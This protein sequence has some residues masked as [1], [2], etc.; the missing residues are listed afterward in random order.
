MTL[1]QKTGLLLSVVLP[2]LLFTGTALADYQIGSPNEETTVQIT[3]STGRLA[4]FGFTTVGAGTIETAEICLGNGATTI[5][6]SIRTNNAGEP[7]S[8]EI[9]TGEI[10][11]PT[12]PAARYTVTFDTPVTVDASTQYWLVV[13]GD[14]SNPQPCGEG[15]TTNGSFPVEFDQGSGYATS[16]MVPNM[17][18]FVTEGGGGG[19]TTSTSTATTTLI[20]NPNQDLFNGLVLFFGVFWFV[21]WFFKRPYDNE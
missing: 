16:N 7:S 19:G 3:V 17:V 15:G 6:I 13:E 2:S 10:A 11:G 12:D 20:N 21:V 4:G 5:P 8:T 1:L 14:A 9:G 18:V